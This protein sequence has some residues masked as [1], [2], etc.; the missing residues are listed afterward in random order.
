MSKKCKGCN[1]DFNA[2]CSNQKFCSPECNSQWVS[3]ENTRNLVNGIE[4]NLCGRQFRSISNTHL[5]R[6]HNI[7]LREYINKFGEFRSEDNQKNRQVAIDAVDQIAR[8]QKQ[9]RSKD[10]NRLKKYGE[11]TSRQMQICYG[12][13]LGDFSI[14]AY[15]KN[16]FVG[17]YLECYHSEKQVSYLKWIQKEFGNLDCRF[18][19]WTRYWKEYGREY[20]RYWIETAC[21]PTFTELRKFAYEDGGLGKHKVICREWLD[22]LDPLG[23]AVWYMD[24][25]TYNPSG[26][27]LCTQ[28]FSK[29][30]QEIIQ[31]YFLEKWEI[32][33]SLWRSGT[34]KVTGA[35]QYS[36]YIKS[37]SQQK[38]FSIIREHIL[39]LFK[40]KIGE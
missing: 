15:T 19:E 39:D 10:A 32:E 30:E 24:D 1:I 13:L 14:H 29:I 28:G 3:E 22:K 21:H 8:A 7:T 16:R 4:C 17:N 11:L 5:K 40:Y 35:T 12:G 33:T 27:V 25:G 2:P 38:W 31:R 20:T 6:S 36:V 9:V 26:S 37:V 18:N 23:L 34:S